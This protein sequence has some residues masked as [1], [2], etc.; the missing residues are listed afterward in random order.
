MRSASRN[1]AELL[2][3]QR[4][5]KLLPLVFL[6]LG[7]AMSLVYLTGASRDGGLIGF[8]VANFVL[9]L[10]LFTVRGFQ[11]LIEEANRTR[12]SADRAQGS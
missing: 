9:A 7:V 10:Y 6:T 2:T 12:Q 11:L 4:I 3:R 8:G 1:W 5:G